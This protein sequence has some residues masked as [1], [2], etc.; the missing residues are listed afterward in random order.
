MAVEF[1]DVPNDVVQT[2]APSQ[3]GPGVGVE[4][5]LVPN[6]VVQTGAASQFGPGVGIETTLVPNDIVQSGIQSQFGGKTRYFLT[7]ICSGDGLR[8]YWTDTVISLALA[9][10][11]AGGYVAGTLVVLG[12]WS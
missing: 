12:S 5:T 9:P 2:G 6:D 7:A 1:S 8:H 10:S 3:F 11:C 4:Q